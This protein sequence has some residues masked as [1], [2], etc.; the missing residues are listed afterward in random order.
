[1]STSVTGCQSFAE[2]ICWL[3]AG[4]TQICWKEENLLLLLL[5]K[6]QQGHN[7]IKNRVRR[8]EGKP[9][10][11]RATYWAQWLQGHLSINL[12]RLYISLV[13]QNIS[14]QYKAVSNIGVQ[15][16]EPHTCIVTL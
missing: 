6:S 13:K 15:K 12:V 16:R 14:F 11:D 3:F 1:M 2:V 4:G 8:K 5:Q 9:N 7:Q 10:Q